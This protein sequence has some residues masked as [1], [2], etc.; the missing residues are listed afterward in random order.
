MGSGETTSC[1]LRG[2]RGDGE[3]GDHFV[4]VAGGDGS[5]EKG[6]KS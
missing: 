5:R 3:R 1:A 2:E 6:E 4:R